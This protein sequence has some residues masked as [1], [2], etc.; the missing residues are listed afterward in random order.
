M[1]SLDNFYFAVMLKIFTDKCPHVFRRY[2][3][4]V[5][6]NLRLMADLTRVHGKRLF[7]HPGGNDS[8]LGE[9]KKHYQFYMVKFMTVEV[10]V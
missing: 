5:K 8:R 6:A 3:H 7:H 1:K 4:N 9:R 2:E 10:T